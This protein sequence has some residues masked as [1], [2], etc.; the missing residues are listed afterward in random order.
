MRKLIAILMI[1]LCSISVFGVD[2][3]AKTK[4]GNWDRWD[5]ELPPADNPSW[6][7]AVPGLNEPRV[8]TLKGW[9]KAGS[10]VVLLFSDIYF[11]ADKK[12][13][14]KASVFFYSTGEVDKK[15]WDIPNAQFAL[16]AFPPKKGKLVIRA[17]IMESKVFKF[18]EQWEIKY[19]DG[20][21]VLFKETRFWTVLEEWIKQIFSKPELNSRPV[22]SEFESLRPKVLIIPKQKG[23]FIITAMPDMIMSVFKI[24]KK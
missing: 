12:G 10:D 11:Y 19:K 9:G 7:W 5:E 24:E 2:V 17:Y 1:V 18:F 15:D 21:E 20:E 4:F 16:V 6:Y 8:L 14:T 13:K 22:L 3:S 23:Q